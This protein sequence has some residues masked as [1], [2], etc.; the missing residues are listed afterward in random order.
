MFIF[1]SIFLT[2][3]KNETGFLKHTKTVFSSFLERREGEVGE[4]QGVFG[5]VIHTHTHRHT[6]RQCG[7]GSRPVQ[8]RGVSVQMVRRGR[9]CAC[10][11]GR[12]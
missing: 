2:Y 7:R 8:D 9:Q 5:G 6:D 11:V 1:S 4:V 10:R 3:L 12:K